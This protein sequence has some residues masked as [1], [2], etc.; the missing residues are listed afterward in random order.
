[1]KMPTVPVQTFD[2]LVSVRIHN[3]PALT[4][5]QVEL[6][7]DHDSGDEIDG[8]P[9]SRIRMRAVSAKAT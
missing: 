8:F 2:V 3:A 1:M 4:L 5:A 6:L 7:F 9:D